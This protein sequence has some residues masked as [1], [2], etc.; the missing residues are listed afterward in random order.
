MKQDVVITYYNESQHTQCPTIFVFTQNFIPAFDLLNDASAW[1]TIPKIGNGSYCRFVYSGNTTVQAN[2]GQCNYT[3]VLEA[4]IG[5][6]YIIEEDNSGIVL[7]AGGSA[8]KKN[9]VEVA[10]N[11][12]VPGGVKVILGNDSRPL[13]TKNTIAFN[14]MATFIPNTKL[15]WGIASEIQEGQSLKSAVLDTDRFFEMDISNTSEVS[16]VLRGNAMD[17]YRF[18]VEDER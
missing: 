9:I 12:H 18:S 8:T 11:I 5:K 10:N 1:K 3:E 7:C 6:R 15:Y 4:E 14:Q 13:A 2:W 16:V 17:G